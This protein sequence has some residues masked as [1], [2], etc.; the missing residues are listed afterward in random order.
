MGAYYSI[1][2]GSYPYEYEHHHQTNNEY[3][4]EMFS[5]RYP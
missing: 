5:K 3:P 2:N 1:N 4:R